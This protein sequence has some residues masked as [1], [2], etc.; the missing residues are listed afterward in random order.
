MSTVP[1]ERREID[2]EKNKNKN[3]LFNVIKQNR[4]SVYS[5]TGPPVGE[6]EK[7]DKWKEEQE[8]KKS[9]RKRRTTKQLKHQQTIKK[10]L[11]RAC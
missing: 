7:E 10:K 9:R 11:D 2:R 8:E 5:A 1:K 6:K 3:N 4:V